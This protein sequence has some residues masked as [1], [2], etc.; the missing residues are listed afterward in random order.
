MILTK[1][2]KDITYCHQESEGVVMC[3]RQHHASHL[4]SSSY[5]FRSAILYLLRSSPLS[6]KM[7]H[8]VDATSPRMPLIQPAS[9][10][11]DQTSLVPT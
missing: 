4:T 9:H 5:S 7:C 6:L 8:V 3:L 2:S 11:V 1:E 10:I